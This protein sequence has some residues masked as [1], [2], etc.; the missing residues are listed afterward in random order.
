MCSWLQCCCRIFFL[1]SE[2]SVLPTNPVGY[3]TRKECCEKNGVGCAADQDGTLAIFD[4]CC[5]ITK[6]DQ[7]YLYSI[8]NGRKLCMR[9]CSSEPLA[10]GLITVQGSKPTKSAKECC[11]QSNPKSKLNE[12]YCSRADSDTF[13]VDY[14]PPPVKTVPVWRGSIF[15]TILGALLWDAFVKNLIMRTI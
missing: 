15:T 7:F 1:V 4:Y 8:P 12:G 14:S 10:F 3:N 5:K 13:L 2:K 9:A 6:N 11:K